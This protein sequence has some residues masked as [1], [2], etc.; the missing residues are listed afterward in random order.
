MI[1][2]KKIKEYCF[3]KPGTFEDF[4][5]DQSTLTFKIVNKMYALANIDSQP[6]RINLKCDP[7]LSLDLRQKYEQVIPGYHMNK[8][9]WNTIIIDGVI[10]DKE[11]FNLIDLSYNLVFISL[12]KTERDEILT[13]NR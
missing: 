11:I 2:L 1:N 4:P 5:F 8:K 10:P 12:K 6:L 3:K 7:H 13:F 9:H